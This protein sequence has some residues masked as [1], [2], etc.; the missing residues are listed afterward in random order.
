MA[1]TTLKQRTC[2]TADLGPVQLA[3]VRALL[4]DA[5]AGDPDGD[6][7]DHDWDHALGGHH[8]LVWDDGYVVGHAAV[9][10][11]HL[12]HGSRTLRCGYV[13]AVVVRA[14]RRRRGIGERLMAEVER[15]LGG[16][17]LGALGATDEGRLLYERRGWRSWRGRLSALTPDGVV[18]T[19]DDQ[20]SVMVRPG[21][22][23]E[24]DLD[25][26]LTCDWRSGDLW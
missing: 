19:P 5:F 13:E 16:Y 24:L 7:D 1:G 18:A 9:V 26:E 17:D 2:A 22:G 10:R 21:P 4:V 25:G 15:L 12:V 8:V 6:F 20:G 23:A 14:D 3:G 11:R